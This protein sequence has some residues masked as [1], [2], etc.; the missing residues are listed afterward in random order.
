MAYI[1]EVTA[2]ALLLAEGSTDDWPSTAAEQK[3]MIER[4]SR[5]IDQLAFAPHHETLKSPRYTDGYLTDAER[6]P[7]DA[8]VN[9]IPHG[10]AVQVSLLALW[11]A[12]NPNSFY[13][14]S[15]AGDESLCQ[16][17]SDIPLS[18]QTGLWQYVGD[19]VK[20]D[21]D[22][23]PAKQ[24]DRATGG[25]LHH[26]EEHTPSVPVSPGRSGG[27]GIDAGA[28]EQ[29]AEAQATADRA[30]G[31]AD[32]A[33]ATADKAESDAA[34]ADGKAEANAGR[35]TTLEARPSGTELPEY[36]QEATLV[37]KS[38]AGVLFWEDV[39]AVPDTPGTQSGIT[40][41]L[42]VTGEDDK[43]YAWR[44]APVGGPAG[45]PDAPANDPSETKQYELAVPTDGPATWEEAG[46]AG[47]RRDQTARNAA[48]TADAKAVAAQA[49][50]DKA[51]TDAATADAKAEA[52]Q[53]TADGA[54]M[55]A[56]SA[57]DDADAAQLDVDTVLDFFPPLVAGETAQRNLYLSIKQPINAYRGADVCQ[58]TIDGATPQRLAYAPGTAEQVITVGIT[59]VQLDNLAS[60]G[61]LVA[62]NFVGVEVRFQIGSGTAQDALKFI[63]RV[64]VPVEEAPTAD[65]DQVARDA[66]AAAKSR[67]DAAVSA[68]PAKATNTDV[69][70]ETDDAKYTTVAK[71]F[72]A[73]ARKVKAATT[74]VAGIIEIATQAEAD[75]GT[76]T[77]TA[78]TPALVKRRIDA[79]S[80]SADVLGEVVGHQASTNVSVN[81]ENTTVATARFTPATVSA[82]Y[83]VEVSGSCLIG[84]H[85]ARG[86]ITLAFSFE[87]VDT[88]NFNNPGDEG[89]LIL[90]GN[91][92]LWT[93][94][95]TNPQTVNVVMT[96]FGGITFATFND[97]LLTITRVK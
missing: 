97:G 64:N 93:P 14:R 4:A 31:K 84:S 52:A 70:G 53:M 28:R 37:L 85:E 88:I 26:T 27:T 73:I 35:I 50:A 68:I 47:G 29:A 12:Q 38:R 30:E 34:T 55:A 41:I 87:A 77:T 9:A 45:I 23:L 11:Y 58:V 86:G 95:N 90:V 61:D 25:S 94:G 15:P 3:Q 8:S 78:M 74:S 92:A 32:A 82:M 54:S 36:E 7:N 62:G 91:R 43:D 5:R 48:A 24:Q 21:V 57:Q 80:T 59:K 83:L 81:A 56:M 72:R 46:G 19:E 10:L 49:K 76:N 16:A 6:D 39:N 79:I 60:N 40:H 2:N 75:A 71:V 42:T 96:R 20:I 33:K 66:A 65:V 69:D 22:Q 44:A 51:E 13:N 63:R 89:S 1:T 17:M 18:I 67:A